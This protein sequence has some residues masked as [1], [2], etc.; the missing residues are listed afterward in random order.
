MRILVW[1]LGYVGTVSAACLAQMGHEVVGIEP[2]PTKVQ[3]LNAGSAAIKEPGLTDLVSQAVAAG[4]L[5]ATQDSSSLVPW[6]DLSLV[7]VGTPSAVDGSPMLDSVQNVT[8]AIA[9]GLRDATTYHVVVL[10]STVFPG[11]ARNVLCSLLEE[12]SGRQAGRDFGLVTNPEFLRETSA[13]SDFHAP[14][15][16]VIGELDSRSGDLVESLY[17]DIKAPIHRV[18][19]EE[20]ELL[21]LVNNAFHA[22]KIGF[23]NEIG[24][25]CD[26]IGIDS[27]AIMQLVCADTKLN[28]SPAYLQPGFAFGGSCLPKDLRSVSFHARRLGVELPILEAVLPSNRLQIEAARHKVH[29]LG[30]QRVAVLGLSFKPG[31]DD[32]RESPV[33]GLIRDL[34]QDGVDVV[35]HDP[36]VQPDNILGSN[37]EYLQRQLPQIN[38]ILCPHIDDALQ[39][40]QAVIVSQRRLEFTVALQSLNGR[41]VVLDLVRLSKEPSSL[42]ISRY[43]GISWSRNQSA[44]SLF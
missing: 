38:Q 37:W 39:E 34:W 6:A 32:L 21:K 14:P 40:C 30:A 25:L 41:A 12:H 1:G 2:N 17:Q 35:V 8:R 28:I 19:L 13:I 43:Q 42:G 11:T 20:A 4:R 7:C 15:Y 22:L 23:A 5:K 18:T 24:R 31:T 16:T 10:R 3:A 44:P 27:H 36:D 29:E 26:P 9:R 33:I